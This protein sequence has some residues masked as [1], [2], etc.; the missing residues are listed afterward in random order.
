M[1]PKANHRN[2]FSDIFRNSSKD[3]FRNYSS[4]NLSRNLSSD[5]SIDFLKT[6]SKITV[7]KIPSKKKKK[8]STKFSKHSSKNVSREMSNIFF[9]KLLNKSLINRNMRY[10]QRISCVS[11]KVNFTNI[12]GRT[13]ELLKRACMSIIDSSQ[14]LLRY[15]KNF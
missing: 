6:F 15:C 8:F 5:F 13:L 9:Q 11:S 10:F 12:S 7:P 3:S 2:Y 14:L 4:S 1:L